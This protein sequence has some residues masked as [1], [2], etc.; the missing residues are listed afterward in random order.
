MIERIVDLE[1]NWKNVKRRVV[2]LQ[3]K[4]WYK[5][6]D[7]TKEIVNQY[8]PIKRHSLLVF[9]HYKLD[10]LYSDKERI[11][12]FNN[13]LMDI[14][15]FPRMSFDDGSVVSLEEFG[16]IVNAVPNKKF[17]TKTIVSLWIPDFLSNNESTELESFKTKI[18]KLFVRFPFLET[19][20]IANGIES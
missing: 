9:G 17:P 5:A 2:F 4:D 7:R 20:I 1:S 8:A 15:H 13:M 10:D 14:A 16:N 19:L 3:S 11:L 6:V 18:G 12:F